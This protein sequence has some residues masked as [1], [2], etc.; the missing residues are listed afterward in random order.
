MKQMRWCSVNIRPVFRTYPVP[1]S[2]KL[3]A[4]LTETF[5]VLSH[6]PDDRRIMYSNI[7][8]WPPNKNAC[9]YLSWTRS[10]NRRHFGE[11][12]HARICQWVW[13]VWTCV[14]VAATGLWLRPGY[15]QTADNVHYSPCINIVPSPG[16]KPSPAV[17]RSAGNKSLSNTTGLLILFHTLTEGQGFESEPSSAH[18]FCGWIS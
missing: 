10:N 9:S 11:V 5:R 8:M 3:L 13:G 12:P 17:F 2:I 18:C 6:S 1:I 14:P 7:L 16:V 15:Q 4:L